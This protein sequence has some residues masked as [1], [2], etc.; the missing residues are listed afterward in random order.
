[1][2]LSIAIPTFN[3]SKYLNQL[4]NKL[5][6]KNTINEIVINDDYSN[7]EN[8][9]ILEQEVSN[10]REVSNIPIFLYF[11]ETNMG[12]FKNKYNC[13]S[14][15]NGEL[16][17]L[18]DSDNLPMNSFDKLIK[19]KVIENFDNNSMYYPSKIFQFHRYPYSAR[20]LSGIFSKYKVTY[21]DTNREFEM[22]EMIQIVMKYKNKNIYTTE[23]KD[24]K[25]FLNSGNFI[26]GKD[27]FLDTFYQGNNVER[28]D[29]ALDAMAYSYYWLKA[30]KKIISLDRF[31]H[32]HRKRGDSVSFTE[33]INYDLSIEKY[34]ESY[35]N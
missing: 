14:Q 29:L 23:D 1:M 25:W 3:S 34:F 12:A 22:D 18:L 6:N 9:K 15:C 11:N 7:N 10:F 20:L 8:K 26:V 32:Y 16:I 27:S 17:Y 30:G 31:Y 2:R 5:K 35:L 4:L 28:E 33:N 13:V 24:I 21:F 19:D